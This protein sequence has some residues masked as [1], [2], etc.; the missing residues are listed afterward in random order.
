M[1]F[2]TRPLSESDLSSASQ[3]DHKWFG[4]YG[5]SEEQL[6]AY[7][8]LHPTE[9]IALI[10]DNIFN[11]FATFETLN[12]GINPRNYV[13]KIP[14]VRKALFV[15]QF[16]TTTNYSIVD[17]SMDTELLKAIEQKAKDLNCDEV[18]EALATTHPYS[19]EQNSEY[20]A[21]GFYEKHGYSSDR[22][23]L[24]EWKPDASITIPCYMFRKRLK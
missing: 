5:I 24:I 4:E 12:V 15:Q 18:W 1:E 23:N 22:S 6:L 21:F 20:D 10:A 13:G 16:T 2:Y 17:M 19:N 3:L 11:G 8:N 9:S 14:D 7:I